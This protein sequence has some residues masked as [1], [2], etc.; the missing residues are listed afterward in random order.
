MEWNDF[1]QKQS[2]QRQIKALWLVH[3]EGLISAEF[4]LTSRFVAEF[5]LEQLESSR[6][7]KL[8]F[9]LAYPLFPNA[10]LNFFSVP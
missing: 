6:A 9:G 3:G 5:S 8:A 2:I 1:M 10:A 4:M 7:E